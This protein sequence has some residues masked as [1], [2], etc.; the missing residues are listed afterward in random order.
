[1]TDGAGAHSYV[2]QNRDEPD[3][4]FRTE[5]KANFELR[6]GAFIT[7]HTYDVA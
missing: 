2:P 7:R 3:E 4:C 5:V 6:H 1:M